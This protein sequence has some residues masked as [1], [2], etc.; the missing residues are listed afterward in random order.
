M[1]LHVLYIHVL[2][3]VTEYAVNIL[4]QEQATKFGNYLVSSKFTSSVADASSM[5]TAA[6]ALA[7]NQVRPLHVYTTYTDCVCERVLFIILVV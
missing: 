4:R 7:S 2:V 3:C 5:L 1:L 6:K